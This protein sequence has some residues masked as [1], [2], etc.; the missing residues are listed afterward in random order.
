MLRDVAQSAH[1]AADA[2]ARADTLMDAAAQSWVW[3]RLPMVTSEL[4]R[5]AEILTPPSASSGAAFAANGAAKAAPWRT[6][7]E[8]LVVRR[9]CSPESSLDLTPHAPRIAAHLAERG[10]RVVGCE[11]IRADVETTF[12]AV[13]AGILR[14]LRRHPLAAAVMDAAKFP[15]NPPPLRARRAVALRRKARRSIAEVAEHLGKSVDSMRRFERTGQRLTDGE[16]AVIET[17]LGRQVD[18]RTPEAIATSL[19]VAPHDFLRYAQSG[20]GLNERQQK[21]VQDWLARIAEEAGSPLYSAIPLRRIAL[22]YGV[23]WSD[24]MRQMRPV[25]DDVLTPLVQHGLIDAVRLSRIGDLA[26]DLGL[27]PSA[28]MHE[29]VRAQPGMPSPDLLL[30]LWVAPHP[31]IKRFLAGQWL[32]YAVLARLQELSDGVPT[33]IVHDVTVLVPSQSGVQRT[34]INILAAGARGIA[35]METITAHQ[36]DQLRK[37]VRRAAEVL[38]CIVDDPRRRIAV[39]MAVEEIET[40]AMWSDVTVVSPTAV[41]EAIIQAVR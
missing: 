14:A 39:V 13:G 25:Y 12:L 28:W 4:I 11:E 10:V 30:H 34:T 18:G 2:L 38:G 3:D 6:N 32:T 22:R 41:D 37:D 27:P 23:E 7:A 31:L 17:W 8:A 21:A 29:P 16:I 19:G 15:L 35:A 9:F 20:R 36:R 40:M 1:A 5:L 26:S 33:E 24:I